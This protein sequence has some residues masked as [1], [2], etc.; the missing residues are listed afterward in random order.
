VTLVEI[1]VVITIIGVLLAVTLPALQAAREAARRVECQHRLRQLGTAASQH[2]ERQGGLPIGC[3]GCKLSLPPG[4]GPPAPQRFIA[5]NV[6][7]LPFL[8]R[9]ALWDAFDFSLP[10]YR[11]ENRPVAGTV[12]EEFL[13]PSTIETA[14][15]QPRGLWQGAAFTDYAGIYGVEG[16]GRTTTD[17]SAAQ[18]LRDDSL[19]VMLYERP[20]APREIVDGLTRTA[21][22]AETVLRRQ[23]ESEW[24]NGHNVFAQEAATRV[25]QGSGIGN[26]IGGPHDGGAFVVFCDAHVEFVS[27]LIDSR[28]LIALLTKAGGEL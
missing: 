28:V 21:A 27:E 26:D 13:C 6:Q 25:N 23:T 24:I 11:P 2:I 16:P 7:L 19:G 5:W 9:S 8:E 15:R 10:S 14:V 1:L 22:I 3:A 20:V 4:G 12:V 17:P 18:W